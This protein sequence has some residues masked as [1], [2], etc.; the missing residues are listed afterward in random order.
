M[1][2]AMNSN[3]NSEAHCAKWITHKINQL[4]VRISEMKEELK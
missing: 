2:Q 3:Q 1:I 4:K